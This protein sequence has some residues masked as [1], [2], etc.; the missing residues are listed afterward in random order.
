MY[1]KIYTPAVMFVLLCLTLLPFKIYSQETENAQ[2][3]TETQA[4]GQ[5]RRILA[6]LGHA[7]F[8]VTA[9]NVFLNYL[10]RLAD[11]PY[12]HTTFQTMWDCLIDPRWDWESADRFI[13]NQLGHPYQGSTYFASARISGFNFYESLL[14]SPFGSFMWEIAMEP[15][16]PS[17]NDFIST[18]LG[19]I[20]LGEMLH[21]LFLEANASPSAARRAAGILISPMGGLVNIYH[22]PIYESGG[23]NIYS[24]SV[25]TG[26]DKTFAY[27]SGHEEANEPW[28]Y[29]GGYLDMNV[30]Y[31]NP[32]TQNSRTPYNHFE[33]LTEIASNIDTIK[34]T[35]VSD[36]YLFS[37]NPVH[38]ERTLLST[39]L[40][41]HFDM[42]YTSSDIIGNL[43]YG[44]IQF[45]SNAI[46]WTLKQKYQFSQR[47]H[48]EFQAH[49][50]VV[51]WGCSLYH[52][53]TETDAPWGDHFS[54]ENIRAAYGVGECVKFAFALFNNRAGRLDI[55]ANGY[56]I[57]SIPVDET[58][59]TGNVFFIHGS[60]DY[61]FPLGTSLGIGLKTSFWGLFGIYDDADNVRRATLSNSLYVRFA[62]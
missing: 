2:G 33:L 27:F 48:L 52:A 59:S 15:G 35:V 44:N 31:G 53:D 60:L 5:E 39:G 57:I 41:L 37:F 16:T 11:Q 10:N 47:S 28:K 34:V 12:G 6:D 55:H 54:M 30:V 7:V 23:G 61:V 4:A 40:S 9:S 24:L 49:A 36:G 22:R 14:F 18:S 58:H 26:I 8:G 45:A 42:F 46:G 51:I 50:A 20:P 21:R 13:V 43:G 19:G 38:T 32:F 25:R 56:H 1:V 3:V 62:F 29:P 17:V